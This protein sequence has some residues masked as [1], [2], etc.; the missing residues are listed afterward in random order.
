MLLASV[1][2]YK[3]IL[4][5]IYNSTYNINKIKNYN[6]LCIIIQSLVSNR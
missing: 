2:I 4:N 5:K 3:N 1:Y 6:S